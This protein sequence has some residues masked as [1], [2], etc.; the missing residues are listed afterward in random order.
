MGRPP[1]HIG[2]AVMLVMRATGMVHEAKPDFDRIAVV[3]RRDIDL[4]RWDEGCVGA[5]AV[6]DR[7]RVFDAGVLVSRAANG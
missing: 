1:K 6:G 3:R 7:D 2:V 4:P 5:V